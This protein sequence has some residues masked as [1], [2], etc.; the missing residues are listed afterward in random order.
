[1]ANQNPLISRKSTGTNDANSLA[2]GASHAVPQYMSDLVMDSTLRWPGVLQLADVTTSDSEQQ[3]FHVVGGRPVA[4]WVGQTDDIGETGAEYSSVPIV[5]HKLGA[6]MTNS[7]EFLED[8]DRNGERLLENGKKVGNAI[9]HQT[10]L[11]VVSGGE[12]GT[13]LAT[14]VTNSITLPA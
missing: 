3:V 12:L 1:M 14:A 10:D 8:V 2:A 5:T 6:I 4:Y 13:S 9:A 7:V 11:S